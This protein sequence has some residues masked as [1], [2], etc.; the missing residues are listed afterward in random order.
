MFSRDLHSDV[1]AVRIRSANQAAVNP[2]GRFVLYWMI[3]QRRTEWNFA[4]DRALEWARQLR[5]PLVVLEALRCDYRWASDRLHQ[6]V[7]QGMVDNARRFAGKA[8]T[9]YPYVEP[10]QGAGQGLLATLVGDACLVVTDEYPC[11]FLPR[12]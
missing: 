12:M 11:F 4:L 1:P 10:R 7:I 6:F 3:A 9:Y 5:K 2:G 8:A